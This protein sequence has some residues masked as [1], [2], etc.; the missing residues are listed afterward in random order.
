M[1]ECLICGKKEE[2]LKYEYT[3]CD[4]CR[5]EANRAIMS[6]FKKHW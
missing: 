5:D 3:C 2:N 6:F 1:K 4:R